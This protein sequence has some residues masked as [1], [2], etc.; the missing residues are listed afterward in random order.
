MGSTSVLERILSGAEGVHVY[1]IDYPGRNNT[2]VLGGRVGGGGP[3]PS[4]QEKKPYG[5]LI[6][7]K[8][9]IPRPLR[10]TE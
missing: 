6:L 9:F 3:F 7:F 10:S 8:M 5:I 4:G 2:F 1:Y